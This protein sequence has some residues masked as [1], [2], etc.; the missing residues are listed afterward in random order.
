[1]SFVCDNAVATYSDADGIDACR[2]RDVQRR[3][4][5][6]RGLASVTDVAQR[7]WFFDVSSTTDAVERLALPSVACV[8]VGATA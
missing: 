4:R 5:H 3:R 6:R 7:W 8:A 2:R 1:M